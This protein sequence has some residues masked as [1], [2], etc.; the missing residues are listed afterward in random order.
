MLWVLCTD[1]H[2][3]DPMMPL[4]LLAALATGQESASL[5]ALREI[6]EVPGTAVWDRAVAFHLVLAFDRN[7]SG[8]LDRRREVRS[9]PCDALEHLDQQLADHSQYPGLLAT[10]GFLPE[11]NWLGHLL[12]VE[13]RMR[14]A[15]ALHLVSCG[16]TLRGPRDVEVDPQLAG[17]IAGVF[18]MIPEPGSPRWFEF[19]GD[20]LRRF[21]D[22]DQ[23]GTIDRPAELHSIPCQ[24]WSTLDL[25]LRNA[26]QPSLAESLGLHEPYT[27]HGARIG[28]APELEQY[29]ASLVGRCGLG[30]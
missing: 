28:L 11:L 24:A 5:E 18:E 14:E 25:Q 19:V 12:G 17:M 8:S 23:S 3:D 7:G 13:E 21:F 4:L 15:S 26:A 9:I 6:E 30:S 2:G 27:W 20:T 29:T 10:Y 1:A 16:L 22:T